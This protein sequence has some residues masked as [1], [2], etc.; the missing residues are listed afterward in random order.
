MNIQAT[1]LLRKGQQTRWQEALTRGELCTPNCRHFRVA[2]SETPQL[3]EIAGLGHTFL[4]RVSQ[5]LT[6]LPRLSHHPAA[7]AQPWALSGVSGLGCSQTQWGE[8]G[9]RW[10]QDNGSMPRQKHPHRESNTS[11]EENEPNSA[12]RKLCSA[13]SNPI[14]KHSVITQGFLTNHR[15]PSLWQQL[16]ALRSSTREELLFQEIQSTGDSLPTE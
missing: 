4:L 16:F 11:K 15:V 7:G 5:Q 13:A 9:M 12:P 2:P 3:Y 8:E 1:E 10:G 6:P 14:Q